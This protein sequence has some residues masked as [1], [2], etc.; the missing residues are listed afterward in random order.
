MLDFG[1]SK[2]ADAHEQALTR[3][4]GLLGSPLYMSPEQ[5]SS[6]R[7]VDVRTDVYAMGVV[8]FELVTARVPFQSEDLPRKLVYKIMHE[9]PLRPREVRD[10]L[11]APLEQAILTAIARERDARFPT[12]AD[13]ALAIA[14]YAPARALPSVERICGVLR[15]LREASGRSVRPRGATSQPAWRRGAV[16]GVVTLALALTGGALVLRRAP[17]EPAVDPNP[18]WAAPSPVSAAPSATDAPAAS[19]EALAEP[20]PIVISATG[21]S[22]VEAGSAG[23]PATS[24]VAKSQPPRTP[25]APSSA[26][27]AAKRNPDPFQR[28]VF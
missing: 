28:N 5:L 16:G 10:D 22:E 25:P 19:L 7:D 12:M 6:S 17:R 27:A 13:F 20:V 15:P 11:P 14:P 26:P 3:T 4:G 24:V 1:I 9:A 21:H 8:L 18:V 23:G 2:V